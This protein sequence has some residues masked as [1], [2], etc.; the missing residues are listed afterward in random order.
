[1][2]TGKT[3]QKADAEAAFKGTQYGVAS[4]EEQ[5]KEEEKEKESS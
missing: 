5:G 4:F 1:M 2:K 3:A